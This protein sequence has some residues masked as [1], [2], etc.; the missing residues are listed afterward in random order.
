MNFVE[1]LRNLSLQIFSFA[2]F[3]NPG[4]LTSI[5]AWSLI[6]PTTNISDNGPIKRSVQLLTIH[7][8][9]VF[10]KKLSELSS[11]PRFCPK[12]DGLSIKRM[13][14]KPIRLVSLFPF[15]TQPLMEQGFLLRSFP[16]WCDHFRLPFA[17]RVSTSPFDRLYAVDLCVF[18]CVCS[19]VCPCGCV[20]VYWQQHGA[21]EVSR[22]GFN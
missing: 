2:M 10:V 5:W 21:G 13:N 11:E 6:G 14:R 16:P 20:P 15:L 4:T 18:E 22:C 17:W 12:K 3:R 8:S 9:S 1:T 7:V 19:N